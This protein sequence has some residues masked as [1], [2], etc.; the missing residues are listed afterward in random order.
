M[1]FAPDAAFTTDAQFKADV[2]TAQARGQKVLISI[3]GANG[4]VRL[5]TAGARDAFVSTMTAIINEYGFDGLDIDFEGH[6]L[7]LDPGDSDFRNPT[8][9]VIVNLIDATRQILTNCGADCMLTMAPETFFVQMGYSFYGGIA[10]AADPRTG[11]YLPVI[12]ALRDRLSF[13]QVQNYNSGPITGLDDQYHTMGGADFHV[14]MIDMLLKGFPIMG[15][16]NH[17]FPA[18]DPSQVLIGVPA[19]VNAGGGFVD[20]GGLQQAWTCLTKGT[21]CPAYNPGRTYPTLRGFMTW[22]VNWDA[23]NNFVFSE[24][25]RT[26]IDA[27]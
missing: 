18:L 23:F 3:G 13:L 6:S 21:S 11:A 22:S 24:G 1:E 2:K 20:N 14:A 16:P 7:S 19:N 27:N 12:H 17:F 4:Q 8:T 15:D 26:H 10:T 25:M 9:P 5:E